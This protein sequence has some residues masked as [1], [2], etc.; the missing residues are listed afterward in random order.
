MDGNQLVRLYRCVG[1]PLLA[2]LVCSELLIDEISVLRDI[3]LHSR[4]AL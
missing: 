3:S 2:L 1:M 4:L